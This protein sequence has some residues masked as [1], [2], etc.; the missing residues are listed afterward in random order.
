MMFP[1]LSRALP[2]LEWRLAINR[3]NLTADL[4][5]GVTGAV[6]V[7]PQGIAFASIAG[8]PPE[9]GLYSAIV[10]VIV[11]ALFGSSHHLISGPTTVISIVIFSKISML[12]IPFT[13]EYI[14]LALTLTLIAG[15]MQFVLGL[16]RFGAMVNFV[17]H[18]VVVGFTSGAAILIATS[19]LGTLF[20]IPVPTGQSFLYTWI[21]LFPLLPETNFYSLSI[22]LTTLVCAALLKHFLPR[23]PGLLLAMMVGSAM[24]VMLNG[25]AH[26]LAYV[27][28]LSG[29]LPP[30]SLPELSTGTLREL[31]PGAMAVAML[32][33]AEAVSIARSV[34]TCSHQRIDN[35]R[36]FIGQGLSNIVGSFFSSYAS[37]GSFTR[38]GV[39]FSAGAKTPMAA[40]FAAIALAL[41]LVLVAPLTAYLPVA[42]MAGILVF[43]AYGLIDLHH[44]RAI[45][46]TSKPETMVLA[47]TFLST[48]FLALEFAIFSGVILSLLLYLNRTS[49]PHFIT[50]AP[51]P[52]SDRS[53]FMDVK[54][55]NVPE[56]SQLKLI[57]I[58]GS[59]FFGAV[60]H[61]SEELHQITKQNPTQRHIVIIGSGINFIDVSGCEMLFEESRNM[62]LEGRELYLCS[63]KEDVIKVVSRSK[64]SKNISRVFSSKHEAIRAIIPLL[65]REQCHRCKSPVFKECDEQWPEG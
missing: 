5:A 56:C 48:L 9:Y 36:E 18:S 58:D 65:D 62:H 21:E 20:G 4:M 50:V 26:G 35:S 54:D 11:A 43:V 23:W 60:N 42:A 24:A 34:A 10:P 46:Y 45:F 52:Q 3:R 61:I 30:L 55:G 63:L 12:A 13:D 25:K 38:S 8:L 7:L 27:G 59:I 2:F 64:C 17:S 49:H 41:I 6:I 28:A 14:K 44:I 32:G 1:T 53:R 31:I 57:R 37:S 39:N 15:T 22:G 19:Q 16:A 29:R 47:V 51:D 40:V 33:L